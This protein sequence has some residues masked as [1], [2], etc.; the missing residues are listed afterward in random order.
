MDRTR[1]S[2]TVY[3]GIV[4]GMGE[5]WIETLNDYSTQKIV[6][7]FTFLLD[8]PAEVGMR[9]REKQGKLDRIEREG[10]GLQ[11]RV[12]KAYLDFAGRD[13]SGRWQIIN[14][15]QTIQGIADEI[16]T[17]VSEWLGK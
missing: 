11:K 16:W 13:K 17:Q 10:V 3:Q 1:D 12:C 2:S 6:P 7:D 9:R 15:Q 5:E 4:R 14:G 8:L